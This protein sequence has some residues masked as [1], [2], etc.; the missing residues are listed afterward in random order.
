MFTPEY[1]YRVLHHM[2]NKRT[3]SFLFLK[4]LCLRVSE[5]LQEDLSKIQSMDP[6]MWTAYHTTPSITPL[7]A[8]ARHWTMIHLILPET[9]ILNH[10]TGQCEWSY[11]VSIHLCWIV[12]TYRPIPVSCPSECFRC[13]PNPPNTAMRSGNWS[14]SPAIMTSLIINYPGTPA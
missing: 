13:T 1:V 7:R 5:P 12:S 8:R 11:W 14:T 6:P 9:W 2:P 10:A 4:L 3:S